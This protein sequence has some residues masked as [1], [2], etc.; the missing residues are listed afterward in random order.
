MNGDGGPVNNGWP[1]APWPT[2]ITTSSHHPTGLDETVQ[3]ERSVGHL[4]CQLRRAG[5]GHNGGVGLELLTRVYGKHM[6][7][8][9]QTYGNIWE[10]MRIYGEMSM[11]EYVSS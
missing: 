1:V 10:Y 4:T 2:G 5:N 3:L 11:Y 8:I 9:W 7:N 6:A